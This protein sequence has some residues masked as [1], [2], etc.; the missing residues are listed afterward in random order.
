LIREKLELSQIKAMNIQIDDFT[1]SQQINDIA[2]KNNMTLQNFHSALKSQG[3]SPETYRSELKKKLQTDKLYQYILSSR[4]QPTND[5]EAL[6]YYNKNPKEFIRFDS[7]DVVR[8][9][10]K[11]ARD[12]ENIVF[13]TTQN[14]TFE[15]AGIETATNENAQTN[16]ENATDTDMLS[17][18][19]TL[20]QSNQN[21]QDLENEDANIGKEIDGV[22]QSY[23]EINNATK[24]DDIKVSNENVGVSTQTIESASADPRIVTALAQTNIGEQ[25]AVIQTQEG[26][27]R[28]LVQ[29][30][31]NENILPFEQVKNTIISKMS[32]NNEATTLKEYFET[33]R[34]RASITIIRLP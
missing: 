25:T 4:Y 11:N 6:L 15:Q 2:S 29:A 19:E 16:N 18:N 1:L 12:L 28:F 33:L 26:F 27:V 24:K 20:S 31:N 9:E 21:V 13:E 17:E 7:F 22:A 8:F 3:I 10:S 5:D 30:K 34:S 14:Q 32:I 23:T